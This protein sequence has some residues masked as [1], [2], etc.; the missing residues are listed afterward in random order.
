MF[1]YMAIAN[2]NEKGLVK[3]EKYIVESNNNGTVNVYTININY[4]MVCRVDS[5]DNW[6]PIN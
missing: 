2:T 4:L 3:G 5:F 1:K 6:I